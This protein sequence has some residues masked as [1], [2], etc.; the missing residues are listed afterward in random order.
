[1]QKDGFQ[2]EVININPHL[3]IGMSA[4]MLEK[5]QSSDCGKNFIEVIDGYAQEIA[6]LPLDYPQPPVFSFLV[7]PRGEVFHQLT[8]CP[9]DSG[10]AGAKISLDKDYP[11]ALGVDKVWF[12]NGFNSEANIKRKAGLCHELA[13]VVHSAWFIKM[14]N[15]GFA[16]LLPH[17]LMN[18]EAQNLCHRAAIAQFAEKEMLTLDYIDKHGMFLPEDLQDRCKCTQERKAY[19]SYYLWMLGYMRR[20][21]QRYQ[22]DKFGAANLLLKEFSK[23]DK[24]SDKQ[25]NYGVADLAGADESMLLNSLTLQ[26][27]GKAFV[28]QNYSNQPNLN[29]SVKGRIKGC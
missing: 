13:H 23:L 24:L 27:E 29:L 10:M 11:L 16:E 2:F 25:K 15:E 8:G 17:Y 5:F 28:M 21:E 18:L 12:E 3:Q 26:Q 7:L 22:L 14:T 19:M 9:F 20:L 4:Q 6:A 1:M